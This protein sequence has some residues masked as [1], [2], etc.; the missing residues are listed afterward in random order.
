MNEEELEALLEK[1]RPMLTH[2]EYAYNFCP[3]SYTHSAMTN[4]RWAVNALEAA[5]A[6][7]KKDD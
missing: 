1:V 3:G 5:L 2:C 7:L 4:S 6:K